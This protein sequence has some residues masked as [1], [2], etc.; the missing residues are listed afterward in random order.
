LLH[1]ARRGLLESQF[2]VG[3]CFSK[4]IGTKADA[5]SAVRWYRKAALRGHEDAAF[6]LAYCYQV[7]KGLRKSPRWARHWYRK[8]AALGADGALERLRDLRAEDR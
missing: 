7:G 2:S 3:Y 5:E 6:N 4:G 8:A 1:A